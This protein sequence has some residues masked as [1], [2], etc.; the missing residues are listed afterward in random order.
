MTDMQYY[1]CG[2]DGDAGVLKTVIVNVY[3]RG[4][5]SFQGLGYHSHVPP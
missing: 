3:G 5:S 1:V 4:V 2:G